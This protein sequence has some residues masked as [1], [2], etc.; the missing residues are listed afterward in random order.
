MQVASKRTRGG[1]H[2]AMN[3][4]FISLVRSSIVILD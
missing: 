2:S 4:G 1:R 3:M